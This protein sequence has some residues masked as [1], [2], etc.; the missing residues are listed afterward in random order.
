MSEAPSIGLPRDWI[1]RMVDA[2]RRLDTPRRVELSTM[3]SSLGVGDPEW[4]MEHYIEPDCQTANS[5]DYP[6]GYVTWWARRPVREWLNGFLRDKSREIDGHNTLFLLSDAG[7]GKTSLLILLKLSHLLRLWPSAIDFRLLKSGENTLAELGDVGPRNKTVLLLDG[8]DE[9]PRAWGRPVERLTD[10]L[11][12]TKAFRQVIIAC[13]TQFFPGG[14][15]E[16]LSLLGMV[17]FG[18]F[19]CHRVYLSPFNDAQIVAFLHK[20]YPNTVVGR[21]RR[22]VTGRDNPKLLKAQRLLRQMKFLRVR[23][24]LLAF[25]DDLMGAEV[26]E[27][28]DYSVFEALIHIWLLREERKGRALGRVTPSHEEHLEAC[29]V[30]AEYLNDEGR[31][32][33][34]SDE[35]RR[36]VKEQPSAQLLDDF[37]FGGRSLLNRS[38]DGSY[39]FS[40]R[41]IQE[42]LVARRLVEAIRRGEAPRKAVRVTDQILTFLESG[43]PRELWESAVPLASLTQSY[44]SGYSLHFVQTRD[45]AQFLEAAS[46]GSKLI[47]RLGKDG[48]RLIRLQSI[49]RSSWL[50]QVR[51]PEQVRDLYGT[52]SEVLLLAAAKEI[53]GED[54]ERAQEELRRREYDLDL[55]LLVVVDGHPNLESRLAR[56]YQLWGQWIP[57]SPVDN[58]FPPLA[59]AFR[60]HLSP[61]DIFEEKD[62]VRGRQII[63]RSDLIADVS[64]R[65]QRGQS[66]GIFGLRKVGKT[67]LVRAVTDKLDPVSRLPSLVKRLSGGDFGRIAVPVIWLDVQGLYPRTLESIAE[68]LTRDL[69]KR[70]RLED[71]DLP[72]LTSGQ[73]QPLAAL[74]HLLNY[75]LQEERNPIC[76]VLDEYDLLFESERGDPAVGGIDE[77]FRMFRGHA[78]RTDRLALVVIGR[79]SEYFDH[80]EMNGRPNPML[81][82]FVPRWLGPMEPTDADELLRRLGRRAGLDIGEKTASMARWWTGG[83]PL[84]HRQ[85]GS[86]LLELARRRGIAREHVPT[87]PFCEEAIELFLDR[88]AVLNICREVHL[89]LSKR[90]PGASSRLSELSRTAA[91]ELPAALKARGGWRDPATR[92]LRRFGLLLGP[93]GAPT[94]PE[95]FR[96]YDRFNYPEIQ[97]AV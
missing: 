80:P 10:L 94:I 8:L 84:L 52:A 40:D 18:D 15:T 71:L 89:L 75:A 12:A 68:Q 27:W 1:P 37:D 39:R 33:L 88:D 62:P 79:D 83:H 95:L 64:R 2:W 28:T 85:L 19:V 51:L 6:D 9:D 87:D 77:L 4:L 13:R 36:L 29:M 92:T 47:R 22:W 35:L 32:Q 86:V 14:M 82:W 30:V 41:S 96:W 70:L 67:T 31:R 11:Q 50:L 91:E 59:D 46:W 44:E 43:L 60:P 63:G 54:L 97:I 55:D 34:R 56:I 72:S 61:Y 45:E 93:P 65:L 25:L 58:A 48:A 53:R 66:L 7:E 17:Q 74:N 26:E 73:A 23:P 3:C 21:I 5:A 42:F 57:W 20:V 69:E 78:Q 81:N 49:S 76:I 90:Y 38:S 16:S 24:M